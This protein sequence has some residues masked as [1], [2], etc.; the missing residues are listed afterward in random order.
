M[1][2]GLIGVKDLASF[3]RVHPNTV[4]KMVREE[5]IPYIQVAGQYKFFKPDIVKWMRR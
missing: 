5:T 1:E 2:A 4:Y 3:L